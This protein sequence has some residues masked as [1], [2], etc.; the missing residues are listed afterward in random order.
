M[1]IDPK[2]GEI[3][4]MVGSHDFNR[5][6][7]SGQVNNALSLNQPG[8]TMKPITY[9]AAFLKGWQPNTRILDEPLQISNGVDGS[10]TLTN[11]DKVYRGNVTA[12]SPSAALLTCRP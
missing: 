8:S 10:I 4:A 5:A 7:I 1:A 12:R 3:L 2:T 11:A 6:D 9:L